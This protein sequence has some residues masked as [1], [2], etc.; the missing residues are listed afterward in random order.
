VREFD[1]KWIFPKEI[2]FRKKP[3]HQLILRR[4]SGG[5][6]GDSDWHSIFRDFR[7]R[8]IGLLKH[9]HLQ[10]WRSELACCMQRPRPRRDE[11]SVPSSCSRYTLTGEASRFVRIPAHPP[12]RRYLVRLIRL[13]IPLLGL[14]VAIKLITYELRY[15]RH[16]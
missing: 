1:A 7:P 10:R 13:K 12:A 2:L 11:R 5:A 15:R 8:S 9:I 4:R 16:N 14:C 3:S 6:R